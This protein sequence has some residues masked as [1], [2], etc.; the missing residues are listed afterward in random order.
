MIYTTF[1]LLLAVCIV[2]SSSSSATNEYNGDYSDSP[3]KKIEE[4]EE[5]EWVTPQES[6]YLHHH[7]ETIY[8]GD[9]YTDA[10]SD[11]INLFPHL[12]E[13]YKSY[14]CLPRHV[15]LSL[16]DDED[17][18]SKSKNDPTIATTGMRISFSINR[19]D[20]KCDPDNTIVRIYYGPI[21]NDG[22]HENMEHGQVIAVD[23]DITQYNATN[24]SVTFYQ[25]DWLYH[26]EITDLDYEM[27]YW[28][29]IQI[30]DDK[31]KD[32]RPLE[33]LMQQQQQDLADTNEKRRDNRHLRRANLNENT[34]EEEKQKGQGHAQQ[35]VLGKSPQYKFTTAPLPGAK[36]KAKII[37]FG[38]LGQSYNSTLTM[39]NILTTEILSPELSPLSSSHLMICA[40]DMSYADSHQDK[41]DNWFDL[42]GPLTSRVPLHVL[43]GNHEMECD[44]GKHHDSFLAY[45]HRFRMPNRVGDAILTPMNPMF[46]DNDAPHDNYFHQCSSNDQVH[47]TY[48][49]G[50]AYY[51][52]TYGPVR[53]ISLNTYTNTSTSS[54]QYSFLQNELQTINR[55]I[56]PWVIVLVHAPIY[57]TFLD[58]QNEAPTLSLKSF[59]EPLFVRYQVNLVISG[60]LHAYTRTKSVA[61]DVVD[62]T[63]KS[64]KYL[65]VGEGG[66]HEG[67]VKAFMNEEQEDWVELRD[68]SVFG[69][70]TLEIYNERRARWKW[71]MD[72][73]HKKDE[74]RFTDDVVLEN[75]YFL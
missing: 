66:N 3:S 29:Q 52:Y 63:G 24:Q 74:P 20:L 46:Y 8:G 23:D 21:T 27:M 31:N 15:H 60:H 11:E 59:M 53:F 10:I 62:E 58:H 18:D 45:E 34:K 4:E 12:V 13:P 72:D 36:S 41:W 39:Y 73:E 44:Y 54:R 51:A 64:P 9:L 47:S 14:P 67:H 61:F 2:A 19:H 49:Q 17:D 57:N 43:P 25:S 65:I 40:G 22:K 55:T 33:T 35:F 5:E 7:P 48:D 42:M 68:K 50:N 30:L 32:K 37:I 16:G 26:V 28:Y 6:A 38:D 70:G 56:T 75:G 71:I 1:L 69:F